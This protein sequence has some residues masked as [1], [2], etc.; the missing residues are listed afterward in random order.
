[1]PYFVVSIVYIHV[2]LAVVT[3][4]CNS[5]ELDC[6]NCLSTTTV[7]V[8]LLC[9]L[10]IPLQSFGS[11]TVSMECF[12]SRIKLNQPN[13]TMHTIQCIQCYTVQFNVFA[14]DKMRTCCVRVDVEVYFLFPH[15][16]CILCALEGSLQHTEFQKRI[17]RKSSLTVHTHYENLQAFDGR[18]FLT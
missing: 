14:K 17:D 6:N 1:M 10:H 8:M 18:H 12:N 11:I 3:V 13:Y 16:I 9:T 5:I 2:H 4:V 7:C 15:C